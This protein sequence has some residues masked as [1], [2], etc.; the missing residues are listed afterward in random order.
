LGSKNEDKPEYEGI[1]C[2]S[3]KKS[4]EN[5]LVTAFISMDFR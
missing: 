4:I 2:D 3:T 5:S 1:F